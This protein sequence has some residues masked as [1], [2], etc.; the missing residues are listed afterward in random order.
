MVD[1]QTT[2][3]SRRTVLGAAAKVIGSTIIIGT[4]SAGST[5]TASE[6]YQQITTDGGGAGMSVNLSKADSLSADELAARIQKRTGR[7]AVIPGEIT[8]GHA[9]AHGSTTTANGSGGSPQNTTNLEFVEA[10]DQEYKVKGA[11]PRGT[12]AETYHDLLFYKG[13]EKVGDQNLNFLWGYSYAE[14]TEWFGRNYIKRIRTAVN[15]ETPREKLSSMSPNQLQNI[16]GEY[17]RTGYEVGAGGVTMGVTSDTYVTQGQVGPYG[18]VKYG[19]AGKGETQK[20]LDGNGEQSPED[21]STTWVVR[22]PLEHDRLDALNANWDT[23][24]YANA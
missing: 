18:D 24:V 5:D 8:V 14:P 21:H 4:A 23:Y 20:E 3:R 22:T 1:K 16:N 6:R 7:K 15:F 19:E 12:L 2:L 11:F 9:A 13:T 10:I 17:V